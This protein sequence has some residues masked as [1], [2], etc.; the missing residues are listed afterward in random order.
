MASY[1]R[2]QARKTLGSVD[3]VEKAEFPQGKLPTGKDI[4]QNMLYLLR[5]KRAGQAQRSR[6]DAAQLLAELLQE[7]WLFCN[8]YTINTRHIKNH[9]LKLYGEFL[10][11]MQTRKQRQTGN[12]LSRVDEFNLRADQVLDVFCE[13]AAVRMKLEEKHGVKMSDMEWEFLKDQ[14][15]ERKMYCEDFVDQKWMKTMERRRKELQCLE[16][17]RD[18]AELEKEANT[19]VATFVDSTSEVEESDVASMETDDTYSVSSEDE[20]S[21]VSKKK[22]HR[23]SSGGTVTQERDE[24]PLQYQHIR[25]SIRKVRPEF[26]ETVDQLKSCYHMSEAQ[27]V[28]AVVTVGR[29]MFGR[30][31]KFHDEP[32]V[33]DLDTVPESSNLRQAGKCL[34]VLALDEI[35]KEIMNSD[36][37]V[38]VTYS[39]DGSK[40]QGAGAFSVQGITVNGKYRSLPTMSIA[41]ES[42]ENLAALKV[43]VLN[44]LEAASGVPAKTLFEKIDFVVTDQTAHNLKVDELVAASFESERVPDHLFCNVHPTLMFNRVITKQ[45]AEIENTVGRDKIYSNFL[46]NATTTA[47]SVTEQALDCMTRLINHNFDHKPWN[48]SNEFDLHI[49]PKPNKSV[50][51]KDERFNRLTLTCAISLYHLEDVASFLTKYEHVSNQLACIVR[52]FLDLDFLKVMYCTGALIGLHLVEP[53]LSLTMSSETTYSHLI[54]AF[55]QLYS[56][57]RE[58]DACKLLSTIEP[59]FKFVSAE[60]FHQTRYDDD[61]CEAISSVATA[62]QPEV[63]KLLK[64]VLPKLADGFQKQKGDIFSF[65]ECDQAAEYSV[66]HMDSEKLEKA[67][68]H[69]LAAER[70]VGFVNYELSRRGAKQLG[71]ASAAQVKAKSADLIEQCTSGSFKAYGRLAKKGARIPEIMQAWTVKQE[72]LRKKGLED[73]EIANLAVDKRRNQDLDKLKAMGGPFTSAAEVDQYTSSTDVDES[74]KVQRLYMEIRYARDTSLSLPKTSDLF[75]LMKDHRKLPLATYAVNLKL[76]LDNITCNT[77][78]TLDDFINAMDVLLAQ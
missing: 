31:W 32:Q 42:R 48:K 17:M 56:E 57:L 59:A 38:V 51:L 54:P 27:A 8:L 15:N 30:A 43:A 69:N 46:V 34:E 18:E 10:T 33:I 36:E 22:K 40:K 77:A 26:Y 68:V 60:R 4:I 19:S 25:H 20:A 2:S 35:V 14:R 72:E 41:S 61:I 47:T 66:E 50:C 9:V 45:W 39:D 75:R 67:P 49:S 28:A 3:Y 71:S 76:Y 7:H 11:L 29:K 53:Y 23:R 73:K 63:T 5:P 74:D 1:T 58:A 44:I 24:L 12:F 16:R 21:Q 6:N 64:M 52:C 78:V 37:K 62:F 55:R 70:S 65:G 13:D